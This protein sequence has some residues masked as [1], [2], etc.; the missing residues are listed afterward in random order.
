MTK[1]ETAMGAMGRK[2]NDLDASD[3]FFICYA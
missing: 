2:E 3:D 1:G